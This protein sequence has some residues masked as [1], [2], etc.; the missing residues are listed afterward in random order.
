MTCLLLSVRPAVPEDIPAI[1][2][3]ILDLATYEKTPESAKAT[4][5]LLHTALFSNQPTA[6]VLMATLDDGTPVG[7]ALYFYNFSTWIGR[8]GIYL[9]DLYVS[10]EHRNLGVGKA[11]FTK[12]GEIA[13]EKNCGRIDWSVLK[14]NA[15]SIAFYE[16]TLG[17]TRMEEW[18]GMRLEGDESI[19]RLRTLK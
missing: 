14:W 9:E 10:P 16:T 13:E 2:Q 8:P 17:A 11:L 3:F 12:L 19:H 18:V 6:H 1:L 7:F 5:E 15:P 4:P